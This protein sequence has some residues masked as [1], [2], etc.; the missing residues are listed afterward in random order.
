MKTLEAVRLELPRLSLTIRSQSPR[1]LRWL[2][3]RL[4]HGYGHSGGREWTMQLAEWPVGV[5]KACGLL[6]EHNLGS[7]PCYY[8]RPR[9]R[10]RIDGDRQHFI[11][12]DFALATVRASLGRG[13][14][15]S[16]EDF[17]SSFFRSVLRGF[18]FPLTGLRALHGALVAKNGRGVLLYGPGGIGKTTTALRMVEAGWQ[19]LA[20]DSPIFFLDG[21]KPMGVASLQVPLITRHALGLL[22]WCGRHLRDGPDFYG[23]L[24]L[25]LPR[26]R[27]AVE[28]AHL[29]RL[30][31]EDGPAGLAPRP[32]SET[33]DELLRESMLLFRKIPPQPEL[34]QASRFVFSLLTNLV[35]Q[36]QSWGLRYDLDRGE[37][38]RT[39]LERL[40]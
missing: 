36:A 17:F 6:T 4:P 21:D 28:V 40:A 31:P 33:L 8:E 15:D 12:V 10:S 26:P 23:K 24:P 29:V 35:A 39:L 19:L 30:L 11:E 34:D 27:Q 5:G 9:F 37:Q 3:A 7:G 16:P 32:T 1:L 22:P 14:L 13:Y 38:A 20:D 2:E 25:D 18:V